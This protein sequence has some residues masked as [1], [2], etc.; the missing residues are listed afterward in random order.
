MTRQGSEGKEDLGKDHSVVID[1]SR[2]S[3]FTGRRGTVD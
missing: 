1:G 2:R 3:V